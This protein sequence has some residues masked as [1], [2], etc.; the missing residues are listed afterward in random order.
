MPLRNAAKSYTN[1]TTRWIQVAADLLTRQIMIFAVLTRP[2]SKIAYL[3]IN[4]SA[5]L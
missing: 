3:Q 1:P 4:K 2:F 5:P